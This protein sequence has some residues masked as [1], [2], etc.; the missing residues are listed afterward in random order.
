MKMQQKTAIKMKSP[1]VQTPGAWA[2]KAKKARRAKKVKK[3]VM[4][5]NN[6]NRIQHQCQCIKL[7]RQIKQKFRCSHKLLLARLRKARKTK[8]VTNAEINQI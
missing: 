5:M 4:V 3:A 2:R 7:T 6:R 8:M 1:K